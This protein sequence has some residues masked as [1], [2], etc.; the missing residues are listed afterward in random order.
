MSKLV[1]IIDDD[2]VY[3]N[4]M[5]NHFSQMEGYTVEA[6]SDGDEGLKQ[7]GSKNP[8]MIILD[9]NLSDPLKTGLHYL[10]SI[11]KMKGSVPV[12]YITSD[13]SDDLKKEVLKQGAETLIIKSDSFLV[14]LRT[15]IDEINSPKKKGLF[16]KLFQ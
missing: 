6:H 9:H 8:F 5:K 10:K 14:Q 3:L 15:A 11:K 13:N 4:F 2:P 12:V 16:S 7:L 1:F